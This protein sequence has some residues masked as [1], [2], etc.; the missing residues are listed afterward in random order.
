M[1]NL[2][3]PWHDMKKFICLF[4]GAMLLM[5]MTACSSTR[6]V[7][8]I[9]T[10]DTL[11]LVQRDT[12]WKSK[13][14]RDSVFLQENT[15]TRGDTVFRDKFHY[16]DRAVTDTLWKIK[17]D[18]K[19]LV[20]EKAVIKEVERKKTWRNRIADFIKIMIAA[21]AFFIGRKSTKF[22]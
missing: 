18:I 12:L 9:H 20:K 2:I 14:L 22:F 15:Y 1:T 4:L 13:N 8:H 11:R 21:L 10:T 7:E 19:Y 17:T 5:S 6:V 16:R 3:D